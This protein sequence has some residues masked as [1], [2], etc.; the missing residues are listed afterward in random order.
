MFTRARRAGE[1][2]SP[3]ILLL[4]GGMVGYNSP[5]V[6]PRPL[7]F[8]PHTF[9]AGQ[10]RPPGCRSLCLLRRCKWDE[11]RDKEN[12]EE[13]REVDKGSEGKESQDRGGGQVRH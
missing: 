12:E 7:P 4:D 6:S 8:V 3:S 13:R 5:L 10:R 2:R 1:G 11:R 9:S